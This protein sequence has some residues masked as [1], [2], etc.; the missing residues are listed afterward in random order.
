[1]IKLFLN[2]KC[3]DLKVKN[4][5]GGVELDVHNSTIGKNKVLNTRIQINNLLKI[6]F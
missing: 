6:N 5:H 1:M 4:V 2:K 3:K